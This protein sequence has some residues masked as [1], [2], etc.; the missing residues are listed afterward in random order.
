MKLAI[1]IPTYCRNDGLTPRYLTRALESV[2][3]QTHH[4]YKVFLIGDRYDNTAE[5]EQLATSIISEDKIYFENRSI[6]PERDKYSHGTRQLWCS[7]GVSAYNHAVECA[8][9]QG[10]D[11]MCHLDHDDFWEANHLEFIN[12]VIES[13]PSPALIYSCSYHINGN[14]LPAGVPLDGKVYE[15]IPEPTQVVHS[16]VC[17]NHSLVPLKYRDVYA[18]TGNIVEADIDMWIRTKQFIY[19]TPKLKSYLI[20]WPT[21]HHDI[22][23][24]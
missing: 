13:A 22:E 21:C 8:L 3:N 18:E 16:S 10:Y 15:H 19:Q 17:I 24:H 12:Q 23:N 2:K 6:A 7:G 4:D 20:A 11:Y 9:T 1:C 5:F 14:V